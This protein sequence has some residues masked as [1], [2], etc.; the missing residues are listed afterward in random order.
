MCCTIVMR[1]FCWVQQVNGA[2]H[3]V[4]WPKSG[5]QDALNAGLQLYIA[6]YIAMLHGCMHRQKMQQRFCMSEGIINPDKA[7]AGTVQRQP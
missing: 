1:C 3:V 6:C 5:C 4:Y 7:G 2:E